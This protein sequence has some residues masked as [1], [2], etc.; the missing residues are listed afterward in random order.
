[1]NKI[2]NNLYYYRINVISV[3]DGD[4]FRADTD[5]GMSV[6]VMNRS[7]R[8]ADINTP[9]LRGDE[10]EDGLIVGDYVR[11]IIKGKDVIINTMKTGKYGRWIAWLWIPD[12][13]HF[14]EGDSLGEHLLKIGYAVPYG[15]TWKGF[16]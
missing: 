8:I 2:G 3:Y 11:S 16:Y 9:E 15:E 6:T 13:I 1:M 14:D 4:T 10:R 5:L 12:N 7:Y